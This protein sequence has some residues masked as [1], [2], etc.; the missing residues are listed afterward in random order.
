MSKS[1]SSS[2]CDLISSLLINIIR[3]FL[4]PFQTEVRLLAVV[5]NTFFATRKGNKLSVLT[6]SF[7]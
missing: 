3:C 5:A 6:L 7:I 1:V 4:L 2:H